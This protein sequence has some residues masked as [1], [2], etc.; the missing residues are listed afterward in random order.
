M[1]AADVP[2]PPPSSGLR[3]G[4]AWRNILIAPWT[5][6]RSVALDERLRDHRWHESHGPPRH[7]RGL[8]DDASC[9]CRL[10]FRRLP[11]QRVEVHITTSQSED[12]FA[13][14][15]GPRLCKRAAAR[16]AVIRNPEETLD[17]A[18]V[19]DLLEVW[20]S[21]MSAPKGRG[22]N[23]FQWAGFR[24]SPQEARAIAERAKSEWE[25]SSR[26]D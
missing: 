10:A 7:E 3:R 12:V 9:L 24:L 21:D 6:S 4:G 1:E 16:S 15:Y 2:T 13:R 19:A 11:L 25:T 14:R 5:N 8:L 23:D 26:R 20:L 17:P 18:R 22:H